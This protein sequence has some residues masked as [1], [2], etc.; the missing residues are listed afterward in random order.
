MAAVARAPRRE[1]QVVGLI[2]FAHFLSHFYMLALVPLY[3]LIQPDIGVTWSGIGA[4]IAAFAITTGVL[5]TPI[6]FLIDRIGGRKVLIAGLFVMAASTGL[7]GF[8]ES[9]WQLIALMALA[10]VGNSVFHPADYSL[11]SNAVA[12]KRLGRA[13]SIHN[14]GGHFGFV[15]API[16]MVALHSVLGWRTAVITVGAVGVA[17]ALIILLLSGVI[18]ESGER[19]RTAEDGP[20]WR[21][22][23]S[24]RPLLLMFVFYVGGAGANSGI[25]NFSIKAFGDIYGLSLT[26]AAVVLTVYQACALAAVLPGGL[27]ADRTQRHDVVMIGC[28][29]VS[30]ALVILAGLGILPFWLVLVVMGLGGAMRGLV[31]ATR[32]VTVR[33]LAGRHS[34]GTAFAF[35]STGFLLGQAIAP[36]IYGYLIDQGSPEIVFWVSAAFSL[37]SIGTVFASR[38]RFFRD[39]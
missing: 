17:L 15:S 20:G 30:G 27:L 29:T 23:L 21:E 33:H 22:L 31:N 9:L 32:D 36:P 18:R 8:V 16:L 26:A 2:T 35:V 12:D 34:V 39:P 25:I 1:F 14:L 7:I 10:G 13:F 3:P 4:A 5:Q 24:S 11:I 6:G 38:T 37:I 28:F 19:R